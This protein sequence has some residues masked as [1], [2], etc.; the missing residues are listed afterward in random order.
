MSKKTKTRAQFQ[1]DRLRARDGDNCIHCGEPC[2]FDAPLY[3]PERASVEHIVPKARGGVNQLFNLALAHAACNAKRGTKTITQEVKIPPL[4]QVIMKNCCHECLEVVE[5]GFDE[6][7]LHRFERHGLLSFRW[8][9]T[10]EALLP[11]E[12]V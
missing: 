9:I 6:L 5:G 1:I 12:A 4:A 2:I 8:A 11:S 3:S 7:V 10:D